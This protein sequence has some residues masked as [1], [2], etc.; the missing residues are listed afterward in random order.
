M[1]KLAVLAVVGIMSIGLSADVQ[2]AE[3][4]EVPE[5]SS[6]SSQEDLSA[7][8]G[9]RDALL[10]RD[11][12]EY[13]RDRRQPPPSRHDYHRPPPPPPHDYHRPPPPPPRRPGDPPP[14][15]PRR[16]GPPPPPPRR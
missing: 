14:P 12:K 7:W 8:P 16:H 9:I 15:P 2:A 10:G 13:D 1:K 6:E 5:I 11:K 4:I 3:K